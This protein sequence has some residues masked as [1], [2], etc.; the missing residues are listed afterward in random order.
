MIGLCAEDVLPEDLGSRRRVEPAGKALRQR[1][2]ALAAVREGVRS[3]HIID[4]GVPSALLLE[5]LTADGVGTAI[6]SDDGPRGVF[7]ELRATTVDDAGNVAVAG[8]SS[9]PGQGDAYTEQDFRRTAGLL[10]SVDIVGDGTNIPLLDESVDTVTCNAVVEH[11]TDPVA[12]VAEMHRV[13]KPG[14]MLLSTWFRDPPNAE[15]ADPF[16]T[17]FRESWI[18]N[19]LRPMR[20]VATG[21][22]LTKEQHDQWRLWTKKV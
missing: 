2:L 4:G 3:V 20:W 15:T 7:R 6:R 19:A 12:L 13:L 18:I 16:R 5:V 14:G 17:V 11:V 8:L 10:D 22:C 1:L 21:G 9:F